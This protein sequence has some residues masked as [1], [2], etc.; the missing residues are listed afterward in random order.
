MS[1]LGVLPNSFNG[2]DPTG[3]PEKHLVDRTKVPTPDL[4]AIHEILSTEVVLL[5][6]KLELAGRLNLAVDKKLLRLCLVSFSWEF[7]VKLSSLSE[8][9][10]RET[11]F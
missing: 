8:V 1:L 3:L 5:I 2:H 9:R 6:L 4:S 10:L 11:Y 7:E